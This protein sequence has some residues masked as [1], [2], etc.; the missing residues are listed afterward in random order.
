MRKEI[1]SVLMIPLLL[2]GG[3]GEREAKL[4]TGFDSFRQAVTVAERISAG[5]ELT[6]D[7]GGTAAEYTLRVEY[8]GQ[9]TVMEIL[10]PELIAGVK[11]T[12][13]W[14]ETSISY[15]SV[16]LAAGE[17]DEEGLTP[18]SAL[19]VILKAM[20]SGYKELLW[21]EDDYITARLYAGETSVCTLWLDGDT[22]SPVA[23][24]ISS[25]GR[26]VISCRFTDWEIA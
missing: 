10:E 6:A 15:E 22:L 17:L 25:D 26:R 20:A 14:G 8:D 2:L 16:L 9:E 24:E 5:V 18:M 3:C 4:E 7:Y 11:A 23:A 1:I 21:W 12:A 19:P 13:K